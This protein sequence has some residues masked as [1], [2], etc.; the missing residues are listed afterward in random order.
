LRA[1][2]PSEAYRL[3]FTPPTVVTWLIVA[4]VFVLG[5]MLIMPPSQLEGFIRSYAFIPAEFSAAPWISGQMTPGEIAQKLAP[6]VTYSFLHGSLL[7][8]ALNSVGFLLVATLAARRMGATAFLAFCMVTGV[9]AA[10][11]HWAFHHDSIVPMVGASGMLSGLVGATARFVKL[12]LRGVWGRAA[13]LMPLTDRRLITFT[14]IWL[15]L[16]YVFGVSGFGT[17]GEGQTI[18]WEAHMGGY[19]AGV[20]LFPLFDWREPSRTPEMLVYE[21]IP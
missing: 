3:L 15:A 17:V 20:L 2:P 7:H 14:L 8:L 4:F 12:D 21:E 13:G 5:A 1:P 6:L 18:A 9:F 10:L 16:N 11:T 19:F